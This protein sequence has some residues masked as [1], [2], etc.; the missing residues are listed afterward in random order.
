MIIG[1]RREDLNKKGEK[2]AALVPETV[3]ALIQAG[4]RVLVQPAVHPVTGE[5][6]RTFPDAEYAAAGAEITESLRDARVLFGLKEID[7]ADLQPDT[8]YLFFSHTHKGQLKNRPMLR[9]LQDLRCTL[10]DYE[11]IVNQRNQRL[12]TAFTYF[13]GYA[14][15]TDSLW[16]LGRRLLLAGIPNPFSVIPQAIRHEDLDLVRTAFHRAAEQ[17]ET[18]GTPASLPPVVITLLG[19]GKT[20]SGAQELLDLL[21]LQTIRP[22]E[23]E[24]VYYHGSRKRVYKL[25]LEIPQMFRLKAE[26]AHQAEGL[27]PAGISRLYI[28][29]PERFESN[30]ESIFPYTTVLVNC[31]LWSPRFPRLLTRQDT[32]EW[33]RTHRTLQVIGDI[34]CDPEGAIQFSRETWIDDPVYIYD[35]ELQSTAQGM[36]GTGIAVMAVTN[37]PCE[38][39]ADASEAFARELQP[40]LA[41]LAN[42]D[43]DAPDAAA[44]GLPEPL[45]KA[46]I[47]WQGQFTPDYAYM[48]AF[49]A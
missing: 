13:A 45:R 15:I 37:L 36:E 5:V 6:K 35:P 18:E 49:T 34:S 22:D 38:F 23:L 28:Q 42:A 9:R 20:S 44:A 47:L 24:T 14:G 7:L 21:P 39:S 10:I 33:Y 26:Y 27:E 40:M 48:Q 43:L 19:N 41:S 16:T 17:I 30:L 11:L 25:V 32:A 4:H 29:S 2:R 12:L 8:A 3:A 31:I 1:L 46:T